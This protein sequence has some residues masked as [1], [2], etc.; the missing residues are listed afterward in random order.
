MNYPTG[1]Q[2][3][4]VTEKMGPV[5]R[6]HRERLDL[7]QE[8]VAEVVALRGAVARDVNEGGREG[9]KKLKR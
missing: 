5:L 1:K 2:M 7:R 9:G 3:A 4:P 6:R 8:E